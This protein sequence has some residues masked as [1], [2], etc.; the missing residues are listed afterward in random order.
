MLS[1]RLVHDTP[2]LFILI[3]NAFG[4]GQHAAGADF[5]AFLLCWLRTKRIRAPACPDASTALNYFAELVLRR[6]SLKS[7]TSAKVSRRSALLARVTMLNRT[8]TLCVRTTA[9]AWRSS[10]A[11][12]VAR[13]SPT[14]PLSAVATRR[15][16]SAP[17]V[18]S[19]TACF[20]RW[21]NEDGS[22]DTLVIV[23][24]V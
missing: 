14:E 15:M 21:W 13:T 4:V 22:R 2:P 19:P 18:S 8:P 16:L 9:A 10:S 20:T 12:A 7:R 6:G 5:S 1:P 24:G 3:W 17:V 23:M 11:P